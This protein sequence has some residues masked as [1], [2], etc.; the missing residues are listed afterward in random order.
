MLTRP[1]RR[2]WA[3]AGALAVAVVVAMV[4]WRARPR[5]PAAAPPSTSASAQPKATKPLEVGVVADCGSGLL[6][7]AHERG[8]FE[9]ARVGVEILRFRSSA[10]VLAALATGRIDLAVVDDL[11]FA[12]RSWQRDDTHALAAVARSRS[13]RWVVTKPG[14]AGAGDLRGHRVGVHKTTASEYILERVLKQAG[15]SVADV[16]VVDVPRKELSR[17]L[18]GGRVDAI[19]L[20]SPLERP[21]AKAFPFPAAEVG[22]PGAHALSYVIVGKR[23]RVRARAHQVAQLFDVLVASGELWRAD[24]Q[25]A[26]NE[27]AYRLMADTERTAGHCAALDFGVSLDARLVE[28]L[29]GAASWFAEHSRRT[30]RGGERTPLY[31]PGPLRAARPELVRLGPPDRDR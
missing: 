8:L 7:L 4:V 30:G 23:E 3:A 11:R 5:A 10:Q 12:E 13:D 6:V 31:D 1:G 19:V 26:A 27:T 29:D 16:D 14:I 28:D 22:S 2:A 15:M 24:P 25:R 18:G 17:A 9:R 21:V 20:G